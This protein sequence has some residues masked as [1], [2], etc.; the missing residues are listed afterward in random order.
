MRIIGHST[1]QALYLRRDGVSVLGSIGIA[2]LVDG[3]GGV[4]WVDTIH[5]NTTPMR[6]RTT[7]TR[8]LVRDVRNDLVKAGGIRTRWKSESPICFI[9]ITSMANVLEVLNRYDHTF[10]PPYGRAEGLAAVSS[11]FHIL[12]VHQLLCLRSMIPSE[13]VTDPVLLDAVIEYDPFDV[14]MLRRAFD[15]EFSQVSIDSDIAR[16]LPY[17]RARYDPSYAA[18]LG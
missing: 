11:R 9:V 8:A 7:K 13:A 17:A 4:V 14:Y 3:A 2:A 16:L 15:G 18:T 5:L 1:I 6:W 12:Q 10:D